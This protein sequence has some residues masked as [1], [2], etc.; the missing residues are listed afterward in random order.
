MTFTRSLQLVPLLERKSFFLLGPRATGKSTLVAHQLPRALVYD[1]LDDDV[2][3]RL[4]KRPRALGEELAAAGGKPL[5]VID[6]IQKLPIEAPRWLRYATPR[7]GGAESDRSG[8]GQQGRGL[9]HRHSTRPRRGRAARFL[10][11]GGRAPRAHV[12]RPDSR[13][14]TEVA[15]LTELA[16]VSGSTPNLRDG[17]GA[18][19]WGHSS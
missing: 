11:A 2:Y 14:W 6:E 4:L 15:S 18:T 17:R 5:V 16:P 1:L 7:R 8:E 3:A 10:R 9:R 12:N 13:G 19:R